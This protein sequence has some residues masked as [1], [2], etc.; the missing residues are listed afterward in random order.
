MRNSKLDLKGGAQS[1]PRPSASSAHSR[2]LFGARTRGSSDLSGPIAAVGNNTGSAGEHAYVIGFGY[3]AQVL[4]RALTLR[5]PDADEFIPEDALIHPIAY[6]TRH[7]VELFLKDLPGEISRLRSKDA[8]APEGH[9]LRKLWPT[10]EQACGADRRLA[11]YPAKL[12]DAV[13]TIAD[14]DPTGQTFRYRRST[15]NKVHLDKFAVI[16]VQEFEQDFLQMF[17]TVKDLYNELEDMRFEYI[18]GTFTETLSRADLFDIA[19]RIGAAVEGG[20][21]ALSAAEAEIRGIYRLSRRQYAEARTAIEK[22]YSLSQ[23]AGK[24]RP[25]KELSL[26]TL[27]VAVFA[28]FVEEPAALLSESEIAAIWGVLFAGDS[29]G[30]G[31]D[32]DPQVKAFL[33]GRIPT[34]QADVI[35]TLRNKP[36]HLRRGLVRLGQ[37]TLIAALDALVPPDEMQQFQN[38]RRSH[39]VGR[40]GAS[41]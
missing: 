17:A 41:L 5:T 35:R 34:S 10:F 31:E 22:H 37:P 15:G 29:L 8:V 26:E 40:P 18:L 30:A 11:G 7:F 4:L 12:R 16:S 14:L 33:E 25:L 38:V 36:T 39:Q 2:E 21:T 27:G 32:Y 9:D 19:G 20:K 1:A 23:L 24:E 13:F 6:S 28:I 3:A